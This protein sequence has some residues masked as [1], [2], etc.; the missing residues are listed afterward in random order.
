MTCALT[1]ATFAAMVVATATA[2]AAE[3]A[4]PAEWTTVT[5]PAT[6]AAPA[7]AGEGPAWYRGFV[8]VPDNMTSRAEGDLMSDSVTLSLAG[9]RGPL[10]VFLNGRKIFEAAELPD[11]P[12]RRFKVPRGILEPGVFN[13]LTLKLDAKAAAAGVRK[14][15]ILAGY[16]D[17]LVMEGEWQVL[18][19]ADVDVA[20]LKP[21]K[22]QPKAAAYLETGFRQS[23]TPLAST[24]EFMPGRRMS[25]EASLA[26]MTVPDDL[27]VE[28]MLAEP[29]VAQPTHLSFDERGRMWVSQYRQYPYPAGL[30]MISRDKYYRGRFDKVPPAPPHHD[31]G[32]DVVSV[33]EDTDGD[34]KFDVNKVVLDGLNMA[35][36]AV[37]GR[38]GIWVMHTPYLM[39]YPDADGDD[40]PDRD[41]EVR[42]AGFGLEDTHSVSNGLIWGPDGWLY[43]AQGSTVTSRVVRPGV[44]APNA[45]GVYFNGSM[46]WRYHPD[47]KAYEIF[48]E[49]GGNNFGLDF[50]AEGRLFCGHNGGT[51][52]GWH[53]V[54][55]G[56]YMKQ[57]NDPG[58][59]GPPPNPYAFGGL[60][61]MA[62][63]NPIP[64]FTHDVIVFEGTALPARYVGQTIGVDPLHRNLVAAE[65]RRLGP[66][67]TTAD[68]GV[69]L[70]AGDIAVRP[71]YLAAGPDGAVYVADFYEE[72]IAH[73]QNYQGQ[74][75]P[76]TG[77]VYR[78]RGK[79]E[80]LN[81]DVNLAAK[82]TAQLVDV[83]SHPNRWH[84][85]TAVRLLGERRDASAVEPLKA[86]LQ[87][88]ETHP[89]L[90]A[91][92]SLHQM[93]ALDQPTARAA[94][95]HPAGPVRAWAVRLVGDAR[96]LPDEFAAAVRELA[97]READ[98][99]VRAQIASTS[100]ALPAGQALPLV[101]TLLQRDADA[102]DPFVPL[103]CWWTIESHCEAAR[104]A[105]LAL[106]DAPEEWRPATVRHHILGRLMRRFASRGTHADFLACAALLKRAPA[107][108]HRK[109]LMAGF[110]E[111]FK[112]RAL[113]PLPAELASALAESGH[114]SPVLRVRLGEPEALAAALK[115]V[116]D[117]TG[118]PEDLL[119]TVRLLGEVNVPGAAP[120]LLAVARG[121]GPADL[122]KAAFAALLLYEDGQLGPAVAASYA[123]LPADVRPAALNL[124][125]SRPAS[126]VAFLKLVE[127][128]AV[129]A[130]DVP[131]DV[132]DRFRGHD[133]AGVTE[134]AA[135]LFP[136]PEAEPA[137][138][139]KLAALRRIQQVVEQSPGDP[140]A[141]ETIF[142]ERCATC[143]TLFFKG[144][145]IGP[146][147]T[148]YQRDDLGTML[149]SILDPSAEVREGYATYLARTTDG[150][151]LSGFLVE[152]D[153]AVVVLRG[154]DG[155]DVRLPRAAI[156]QMKAAGGS[157]M[158]EGLLDGLD[159][160]QVR[161]LFAYLRIPQ[162]IT[163]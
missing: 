154:S 98:A 134:L 66:T 146:N 115:Q 145:D 48:A 32:R 4:A 88:V 121:D 25:P 129:K 16:F 104:D 80:K 83:L 58:K 81:A 63:A 138:A 1:L 142:M 59:Y 6:D 132:V 105:V 54:Q 124:L 118:T 56:L 155:Q 39:F 42:L 46:V 11:E 27:T 131:P 72:F 13:V 135:K 37:R 55:W 101:A 156:K 33:H 52:R 86:L 51:T 117:R 35:N 77:R 127:A 151:T 108:E 44:D 71:V 76:T 18:R 144:G 30:K 75:D 23:S 160:R 82:S 153:A 57:G 10:L 126:S 61:M 60:T 14:A 150:R 110:E 103:L 70:A 114:A 140:Y 2:S 157:L 12:R 21:V 148:S 107:D 26:T 15:P 141:G 62:S 24:D 112:G 40:V 19:A 65:R 29:V 93:G 111:A 8:R 123:G 152:N 22:E 36:A 116:T 73:G 102:T 162:P 92:W 136:A 34:G 143:H 133:D 99:E 45:P 43:G 87:K 96:T 7:P 113:P 53:F 106:L 89:A 158:P 130:A 17:E 120:A 49:G 74:I 41:P 79:N 91:L 69:P 95:A 38:G 50:D 85:Q 3:P 100:R 97:G 31:R 28:L 78:L 125:A 67:F 147:L 9:I 47:T 122:R 119:A 128:G 90:E 20:E 109:L 94:L 139:A 68:T 137:R 84:R 161:D 163:R 5:V 149:T 159:D 64:R